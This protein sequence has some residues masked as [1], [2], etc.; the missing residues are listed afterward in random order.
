MQRLL[1]FLALALTAPLLAGGSRTHTSL[2]WAATGA[3][4]G[5]TL[6]SKY[7]EYVGHP[8]VEQKFDVRLDNAPAFTP[9]TVSV[10]GRDLFEMSTDS[11]GRAE[12][13]IENLSSPAV[14]GGRPAPSRRINTGSVL[15][16]Y[17]PA[18]GVDVSANYVE[19]P[20]TP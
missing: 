17:N 11:Q 19:V 15:R 2:E 5:M 14:D 9:V 13:I 3:G 12:A 10:D 20:P 7:V 4:S 16:V 18:A 8:R 1:P 6:D